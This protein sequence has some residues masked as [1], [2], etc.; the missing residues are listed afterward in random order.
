MFYNCVSLISVDLSSSYFNGVF[1][2]SYMFSNCKN[3]QYIKLNGYLDWQKGQM[4]V[5]Y[6]EIRQNVI[7]KTATDNIFQNCI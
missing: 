4:T 6:I 2:L 1:D 7:I 3:L 5:Y